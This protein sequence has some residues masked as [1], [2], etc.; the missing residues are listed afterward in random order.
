M[1]DGLGAT[2]LRPQLPL[3]LIFATALLGLEG[4]PC[5]RR[6]VHLASSHVGRQRMEL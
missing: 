3:L 6:L 1:A 5:R 2:L 4:T